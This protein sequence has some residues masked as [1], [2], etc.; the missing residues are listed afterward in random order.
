MRAAELQL[1]QVADH[2]RLTAAEQLG[3]D[4]AAQRGDEHQDAAGDDPRHG[5][6]NDDPLQRLPAIGAEIEGR[7]HQAPVHLLQAGVDRQH[8]ERQVGVEQADD[9]RV[10]GVE[11][12]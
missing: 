3:N 8:H 1:D 2:Q 6:R 12:A 10:V 11:N 5:Q 9:H 4:V 7:F